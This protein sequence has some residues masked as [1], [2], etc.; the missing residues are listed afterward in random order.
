MQ[1]TYGRLIELLDLETGALDDLLSRKIISPL[2]YNKW[3]KMDSYEMNEEFLKLV[4]GSG[5]PARKFKILLKTLGECNQA[6]VVNFICSG[7]SKSRIIYY[8]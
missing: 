3:S 4:K 7:G 2:Q 1:K 5:F 6:H 8:S